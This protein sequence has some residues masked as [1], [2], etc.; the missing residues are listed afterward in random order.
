MIK[1][2]LVA[3]TLSLVAPPYY[4]RAVW[5][6]MLRA[7]LAER[8]GERAARSSP[9]FA[10]ELCALLHGEAHRAYGQMPP[11]AAAGLY[12]RIAPSAAW[13]RVNAGKRGRPAQPP[14]GRRGA[15]SL[16]SQYL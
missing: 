3:D 10:A 13:D 9:P 4:D 16:A 8:S 12:E 5:H 11:P 15:P 6:E 1:E 14:V 2:A 7:R